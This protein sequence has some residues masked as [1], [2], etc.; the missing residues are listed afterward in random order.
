LIK[1]VIAGLTLR[2]GGLT[3][4]QSVEGGLMLGQGGE[5]AFIII[6][7]A[8]M[9]GLIDREVGQFM[10]LVVGLSMFATPLVS[11]L[12]HVL[13]VEI[14]RR[15]STSDLSESE[16]VP[17]NL[18]GHVVIAGFGR[19][20]QLVAS[21]LDEQQIASLAV[22]NDAKE[23]RRWFGQR[24]IVFGDASRPELLRKLG[25]ERAAAV[26]LTMDHTAAAIRTVRA[27][28]LEAPDVPVV[29]RARDEEHALAL[30]DAG[31]TLVVPETLE[32]GLQLSGF[33]LSALGV[34]EEAAGRILDMRREE[35]IALY[36]K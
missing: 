12:G 36:R 4:A 30:R 28:R 11:R 33:A 20:G 19:V 15:W 35:R 14:E 10:L 17:E 5:F 26:V 21:V 31:A 18:T 27:I 24:P 1:A 22:E 34:P 3:P 25:I 32:S 8:I 6:G 7:A 29:A 16:A 2:A 13:G 23:V 9:Y